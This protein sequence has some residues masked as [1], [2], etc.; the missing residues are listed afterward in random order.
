MTKRSLLPTSF[1]DSLK[2]DS[3]LDNKLISAMEQLKLM[4]MFGTLN[5]KKRNKQ[6]ESDYIRF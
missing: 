3:T 1:I 4:L 2:N 6:L 5:I